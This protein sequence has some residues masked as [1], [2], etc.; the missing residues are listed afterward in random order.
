MP[1]PS[2]VSWTWDRNRL[3]RLRHRLD[4]RSARRAE[5]KAPL[6]FDSVQTVFLMVGH[7]G[8]EAALISSVLDAHPAMTVTPGC[9]VL[10]L[11]AGGFDRYSICHLL[12]EAARRDART[13]ERR[14]RAAER[15]ANKAAAREAKQKERDA[16][17]SEGYVPKAQREARAAQERQKQA[18]ESAGREQEIRADI[19]GH[20]TAA[21]LDGWPRGAGSDHTVIGESSAGL[22]TEQ[23]A[24]APNL[25]A[26]LERTVRPARL[27]V[28]HM[29]S[30]PYDSVTAIAERHR[31]RID[32]ATDLYFTCCAVLDDV[33]ADVGPG[34]MTA[35]RCED[36]L[37][38]PPS[39]LTGILTWLGVEP[40]GDYVEEA[41]R[42]LSR[43]PYNPRYEHDWRRQDLRSIEERSREHTFLEG[44]TFET[45][46]TA[47]ITATRDLWARETVR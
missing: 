35:I 32:E 33:S 23:I 42:A 41:S 12:T 18:W 3:R 43:L 30:N 5:S 44:Y 37:T 26:E 10:D 47:T 36:V 27:K 46:S 25:L 7:P 1:A 13:A 2:P 9:D 38:A 45:G 19:E 6:R 14:S 16:E 34:L 4:R 20:P 15:D 21:R 40:I 39:E 24:V 28:L 31:C 17:R 8:R 11:V 29:V 22:T